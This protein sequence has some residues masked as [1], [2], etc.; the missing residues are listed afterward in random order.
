M[1]HRRFVTDHVMPR[2]AKGLILSLLAALVCGPCAAL[3]AGAP[4]PSP[5]PAVA[6]E[7][8]ARD[9]ARD[10]GSIDGIVTAVYYVPGKSKMVVKSGATSYDLLVLPGTNVQGPTHDFVVDVRVGTRVSVSASKVGSTYTAQIIRVV[11][12]TM[13]ALH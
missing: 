5:A 13:R 4:S 12:Q 11:P 3:A 1:A 2:F 10:A 7:A 6:T 9:N 8:A